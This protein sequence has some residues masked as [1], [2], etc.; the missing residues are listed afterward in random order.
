MCRQRRSLVT[1]LFS[2]LAT[3]TFGYNTAKSTSLV[4]EGFALKNNPPDGDVA[5]AE[6]KANRKF[7]K[8]LKYNPLNGNALVQLGMAFMRDPLA[9]KQELAMERLEMAFGYGGEQNLVEPKIPPA[10]HQ[11]CYLALIIGRR[12]MQ[13]REIL[14]AR[15]FFDLAANSAGCEQMNMRPCSLMQGATT[16]TGY[17]NSTDGARQ[18]MADYH[19]RMDVLLDQTA[20]ELSLGLLKAQAM[21]SNVENFCLSTPFYHEVCIYIVQ[22]V[23]ACLCMCGCVCA[24]VRVCV[25]VCAGVLYKHKK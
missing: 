6:K 2:L 11:A 24:C 4:N 7:E 16:L 3:L 12:R 20:D 21:D 19:R 5:R 8:A 13:T 10:S 15:F 23:W 22:F 18:E 17:P 25:C 1:A 14:K 9:S